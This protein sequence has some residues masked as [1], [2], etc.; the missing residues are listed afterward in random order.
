MILITAQFDYLSFNLFDYTYSD[1]DFT[2]NTSFFS[3]FSKAL[4][5][6]ARP[7]LSAML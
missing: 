2:G 3:T 6:L 7:V 4:L 5:D 1:A